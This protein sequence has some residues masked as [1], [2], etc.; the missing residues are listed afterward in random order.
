M[1]P[2]IKIE[3]RKLFIF[4]VIK[5]KRFAYGT[6]IAAAILNFDLATQFLAGTFVTP[7]CCTITKQKLAHCVFF[8]L[9]NSQDL[10]V[11]LYMAAAI[12]GFDLATQFSK[13]QMEGISYSTS[14]LCN[15][16]QKCEYESKQQ[17]LGDL[18]GNA[19]KLFI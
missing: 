6:Y 5:L 19:V 17:S 9:S 18:F 13:G 4:Q 11:Y 15:R 1:Q 2:H 16:E 14:S 12:L 10:H 8:K 3:V 7:R